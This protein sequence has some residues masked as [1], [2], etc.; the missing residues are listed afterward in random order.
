MGKVK[1]L[2]IQTRRMVQE[3]KIDLAKEILLKL[4]Y[5]PEAASDVLQP[6]IE[7]EREKRIAALR[8]EQNRPRQ[9]PLM[10]NPFN[11]RQSR[12]KRRAG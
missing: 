6:M 5:S 7:E 11:K 10:D 1:E 8:R 9:E 3:G 4:G 2:Y 12:R